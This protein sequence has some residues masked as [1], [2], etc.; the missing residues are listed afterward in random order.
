MNALI[1]QINGN[2]PSLT[3]FDESESTA[4][5][6]TWTPNRPN[7]RLKV[8]GRR[9]ALRAH[10]WHSLPLSVGGKV[11]K[12]PHDILQRLIGHLIED[13]VRRTYDKSLMMV[14]RREFLKQ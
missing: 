6:H 2:L 4:S 7:K 11:M 14:V 13:K 9:V 12:T 10:G 3:S 8:L 1:K 5:V